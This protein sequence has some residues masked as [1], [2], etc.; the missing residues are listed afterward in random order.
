M[1][2]LKSVPKK[3]TEETET[4]ERHIRLMDNLFFSD[5]AASDNRI[6]S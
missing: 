4:G 1:I 5:F 6:G 2:A 3:K